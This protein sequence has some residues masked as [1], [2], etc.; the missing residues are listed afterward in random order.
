M[1][2]A[3]VLTPMFSVFSPVISVFYGYDAV[4]RPRI[5]LTSTGMVPQIT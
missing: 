1:S 4:Y 3:H 2:I 5:Y